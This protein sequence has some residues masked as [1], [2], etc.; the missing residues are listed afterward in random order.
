MGRAGLLSF[1]PFNAD[2][3]VAFQVTS[4]LGEVTQ[5]S[6]EKRAMK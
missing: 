5:A 3:P 1:D 6:V 2:V 4:I